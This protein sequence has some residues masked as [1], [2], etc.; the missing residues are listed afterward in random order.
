MFN[1]FWY[2]GG[3]LLGHMLTLCLTPW[4]IEL[5]VLL[6]ISKNSSYTASVQLLS[7][8]QLFAT[9]WTAACQTSLSFTISQSLLKLMS[10]ECQWCH[11]TISSFVVPFSSCL[12]SFPASDVFPVS[13]LFTSGGQSIGAS[14][15]VLPMNIQDW[16]PL[17]LP[18]LVS[19][20]SKGLLRVFS[21]TR[22]KSINSSA[23][24]QPSLWSTLTSMHDYRRNHSF[25]YTAYMYL[26][27]H[28]I[29][30]LWV[31]SLFLEMVFKNILINHLIN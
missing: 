30:S 7:R 29:L 28:T 23:L 24:T 17:G 13:W 3:E 10:I 25:D 21:N 1:S 11:P 26:I 20:Q 6:L 14:A 9:P 5:F 2:V 4:G 18:G 8:V 16:F 27:R 19:F 15:S 22:F 12:Q 31:L